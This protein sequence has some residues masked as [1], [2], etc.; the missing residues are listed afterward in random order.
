M[1]AE[2]PLRPGWLRIGLPNDTT[3][4]E[5]DGLVFE[6]ADYKLEEAVYISG[7]YTR[8]GTIIE[9]SVMSRGFRILRPDEELSRFEIDERERINDMYHDF[10]Y[11]Q[12]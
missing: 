7:D 8:I 2:N 12:I 3:D 9:A 5:V 1:S 10:E 4:E 11:D 6:V